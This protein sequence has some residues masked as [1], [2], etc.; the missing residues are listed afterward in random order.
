MS[1][2][3]NRTG[4]SL[5]DVLKRFRAIGAS[6]LDFS[7]ASKNA[8]DVLDGTLFVAVMGNDE[9]GHNRIDEAVANGC[10]GI[11]AE[12]FVTAP[13]PVFLVADTRHAFQSIE[14]ELLGDPASQLHTVGITG[15]YGKTA[16]ASMLHHALS[17]ESN[18]VGLIS[19]LSVYDGRHTTDGWYRD[20]NDASIS[21]PLHQM[22]MN[23]CGHAILE[24]HSEGL[25]NQRYDSISLDAAIIT[26]IRNAHT[27]L[28]GTLANYRR[29]K[30][31]ILELLKP[32]GVVILNSDDPNTR[33]HLPRLSNP[34][35]T[36]GI[37]TD[38]D[39]T[40]H[41]IEHTITGTS[42]TVDAGGKLA[43]LSLPLIGTH[44]VY[45]AL[46][47]IAL[48]LTTGIELDT[49]VNRFSS[50]PH[51]FGHM[52]PVETGVDFDVYVDVA[53]SADTLVMA[54]ESLRAVTTGRLIVLMGPD[55]DTTPGERR[56][57]GTVTERLS[58]ICICTENNTME[59]DFLDIAHDCMDGFEHPGRLSV[60]P[61]RIHAIDWALS[62]AETGDAVL[63]TGKGFNTLHQVGSVLQEFDDISIVQ[64]LLR[65]PSL[66]GS[67][68]ETR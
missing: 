38:A 3:A 45:H 56:H 5:R 67:D 21:Q 41:D 64:M 30:A 37:H 18:P 25:I 8:G 17:S 31:R 26:R 32:D 4:I 60:I 61:S 13:V 62:T 11:L 29:A 47:A 53:N 14:R 59:V 42:F 65:E 55:G 1:S 27:T 66:F 52:N 57:M 50:L 39:I 20:S 2:S 19:D 35:L 10:I 58:D 34:A 46:Q 15:S 16:C 23:G 24:C 51:P 28:H 43:K 22:V 33:F 49:I 12:R 7:K 54:M 44:H 63:I 6:D 9:D 36:I 68:D 48:S 40:A